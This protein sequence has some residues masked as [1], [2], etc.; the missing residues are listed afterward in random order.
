MLGNEFKTLCQ[1]G[2]GD[3]VCP[4]R[5]ALLT[6]VLLWWGQSHGASVLRNLIAQRAAQK[7]EHPKFASCGTA[8]KTDSETCSIINHVSLA[9]FD[10]TNTEFLIT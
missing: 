2:Y 1:P 9:I 8:Y 10:F 3:D 5:L 6:W 7:C 4:A